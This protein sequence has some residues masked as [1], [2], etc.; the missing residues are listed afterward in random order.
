MESWLVNTVIGLATQPLDIIDQYQ[1]LAKLLETTE[2][3]KYTIKEAVQAIQELLR[4]TF[5][6]LTVTLKKKCKTITFRK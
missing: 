4:K 6:A 3:A 5:A 2:C 1:C